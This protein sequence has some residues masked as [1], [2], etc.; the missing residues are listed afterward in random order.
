M[1]RFLVTAALSAALCSAALAQAIPSDMDM[2]GVASFRVA[3]SPMPVEAVDCNLDGALLGSELNEQL[4]REGLES[5]P[6]SAAVAILTVLSTHD[7]ENGNCTSTI[8]LGAYKK[9]S[10]FD[11]AVGWVRTGYVVIWQSALHVSSPSNRHAAQSRD[12]IS[13]LAGAM[14]ASWRDSNGSQ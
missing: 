5:G 9:A 12:A 13:L 3:I 2:Q 14:L 10:F 1:F 4:K 6:E 8:M 7:A 11:D